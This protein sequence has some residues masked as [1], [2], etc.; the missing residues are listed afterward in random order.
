MPR[1]LFPLGCIVGYVDV[2]DNTRASR[3]RWARQGQWHWLLRDPVLIEPP[4]RWR[5]R[6][7]L[8]RADSPF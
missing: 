5:G 2:Y 3:S 8:F 1:D 4:V 6:V 7:G